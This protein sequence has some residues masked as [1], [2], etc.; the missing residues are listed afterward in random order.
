MGRSRSVPIPLSQSRSIPFTL[1]PNKKQSR[2]VPDYQTQNR[3]APFLE[4]EMEQLRSIWLLNQTLLYAAERTLQIWRFCYARASRWRRS[5][6]EGPTCQPMWR[7]SLSCSPHGGGGVRRLEHGLSARE[8]ATMRISCE[9]R[10]TETGPRMGRCRVR[11]KGWW[12]PR[13]V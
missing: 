6:L 9:A 3:A 8:R 4:S 7:L 11:S 5:R 13:P 12:G 1:Q 2:S 10:L